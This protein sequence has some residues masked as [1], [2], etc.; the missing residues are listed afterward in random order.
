MVVDYQKLL[1]S[2]TQDIKKS[3]VHLKY[4]YEKVKNLSIHIEK[5]DSETLE[6]WEGFVARFSR[7]SDIFVMKYLKTKVKLAE[8]GF[9]G[10]LLDLLNLSEKL[11]LIEDARAWCRIRELRNQATHDYTE[12]EFGEYL[13]EIRQLAPAIL[14]I[15]NI[16]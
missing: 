16:L 15:E 4:S 13:E 2:Y 5:T 3:L 11:N 8:P 1:E 10:S 9:R 6:T 14:A 7:V 12:E